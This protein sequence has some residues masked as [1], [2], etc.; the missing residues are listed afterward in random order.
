MRQRASGTPCGRTSTPRSASVSTLASNARRDA[1]RR[2]GAGAALALGGHEVFARSAIDPAP[3]TAAGPTAASPT[4]LSDAAYR[5]IPA[6]GVR[7][8]SMG[9]GTWLTFDLAPGRPGTDERVAVMQAFLDAGGGMIDSS[10][11]YGQAEAMIGH[12]LARTTPPPSAVAP[13]TAD[14]S[15]NAGTSG[16]SDGADATAHGDRTPFSASKIWTPIGA[17][18]EGQMRNTET[19][20]GVTPMDLMQVHNLV[21][22]DAHLPRLRDWKAEGRIRHVGVTTSHGRRHDE[23]EALMRRETLDSVQLTLNLTHR[24]VEA[25]LL[26]LAAERGMAVIVNRPLDGGRLPRA[27]AA[28]PLSPLAVELGCTSWAQYCLLF[29]VSHPAVTVAIPATTRVE[30]VRENMAVMALPMPDAATREAMARDIA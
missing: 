16:R 4:A 5:S 11:M 21:G 12:A 28:R 10:P 17:M 24:A 18:A 1:L 15:G 6:S 13:A 22:L 9:M 14:A 3:A 30:H 25:R 20:W 26:P 2:L 27:L 8:P 29:V 19:L 23:L 7:V